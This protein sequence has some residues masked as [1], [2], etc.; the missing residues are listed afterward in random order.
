MSKE[1]SI[2]IPIFNEEKN[3]LPLTKK[4]IKT[5]KNYKF[6]I[7]FVDDSS[8]DDSRKILKKLKKKYLFFKP[9]FRSGKRDLSKSCISGIKKT[10]YSKILIM[11]GDLQHDP[12]YIP[13]MYEKLNDNKL[14]IVIGT[15]KLFE[16]NNK[17]LSETRR[18]VSIFLIFC[19]KIF[20][21]KTKDPMSGFFMFDK[22]IYLKNQKFFFGKGFK[23]L[24]DFLINCKQ[25]LKTQD[26]DINFNRRYNSKSKM[27]YRILLILIYFYL[28]SLFN[29]YLV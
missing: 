7:T 18:Y 3:I 24:A 22:K 16:P 9:I 5:L 17:G 4:I 28:K 10:K 14:D 11:D 13:S 1:L 23:I 25:T 19:F 26:V 20:N 2:V 15:R 8:L 29:K 6:E 27:S 12:K 21:I